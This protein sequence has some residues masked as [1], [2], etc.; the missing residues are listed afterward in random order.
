M[1]EKTETY[2]KIEITELGK[3]F[4]RKTTKI[5]EDGN[6]LSEGHHREIRVPSDDITDLPQNVQDT[7]ST[8]WTQEIKDN[9]TAHIQAE[10]DAVNEEVN[11]QN[12]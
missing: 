11:N 12:T 6:I 2:T 9:W 10:N 7:V 5:T 8:Y 3:V 4:L 1:L